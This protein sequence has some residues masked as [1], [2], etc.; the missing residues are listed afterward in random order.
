MTQQNKASRRRRNVKNPRQGH[1]QRFLYL[2][3]AYQLVGVGQPRHETPLLQPIDGGERAGEEDALHRSKR[4]KALAWEQKEQKPEDE[5]SV[6]GSSEWDALDAFMFHTKSRLAVIYPL[7]SP[8]CFPLHTGHGL[9][10]IEEV[11]P[12]A[13]TLRWSSSHRRD[14][15]CHTFRQSS[16]HRVTVRTGKTG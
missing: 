8:I 6:D 12:G 11:V 2:I 13:E 10:G 3:S 15:Q 14:L 4:H 5:N 16:E 7:K 9:N 1:K